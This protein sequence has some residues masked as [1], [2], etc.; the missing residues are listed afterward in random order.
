MSVSSSWTTA[1]DETAAP[2]AVRED[3]DRQRPGLVNVFENAWAQ[4]IPFLD[5]DQDIH[6]VIYTTNAI[7]SMNHNLRTL[8]NTTGRFLSDDAALKKLY[9][10][11]ATSR[12][13]TST[14]TK[15]SPPA[16]SAAP[17]PSAGPAP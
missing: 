11:S 9:P 13:A 15:R 2:E 3:W 1:V 14:A 8:A 7:E 16:A 4:F 12:A 17:R 6:R 10:A 5:F